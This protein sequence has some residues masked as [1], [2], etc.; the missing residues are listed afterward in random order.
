MFFFRGTVGS[1]IRGGIGQQLGRPKHHEKNF[2][3]KAT[4]RLHRMTAKTVSGESLT[5]GQR[6]EKGRCREEVL[7]HAFGVF[8]DHDMLSSF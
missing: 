2:E 4:Y 7:Q 3:E 5:N 6:H 8:S 1:V